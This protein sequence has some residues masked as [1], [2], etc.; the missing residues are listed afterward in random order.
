MVCESGGMALRTHFPSL[1]ALFTLAL[2]VPVGPAA[3]SQTASKRLAVLEF[4]GDGIKNEVKEAFAEAV[5]G[6]VGDGLAGRGVKV[7]DRENMMVLLKEMGKKECNEGECEVETARNIGADFVVSGSV[8]K[9]DDIFV[10]TLKLHETQEGSRLDTD[11]IEAKTQIEVLRSLRE[12]GRALVAKNINPRPAVPIPSRIPAVEPAPAPTPAPKS[13]A[14]CAA[15]QVA[16]PGGKFW[17]GSE[18]GDADEKPVRRVTLSPYC[19][20]K[21]EVTVSA[22]RACV[23]AGQ[24]RPPSTTVEWK[25]IKAEDKTKWSQFCTWGKSGL[26]QHPIN[27]VDWNQATQYCQWT[28]GR[29]PNE[30]EWEFAARGSDSRK[31]PWGNTAPDAT[32]LN[33]CGAECVS[34]A[35][36]RMGSDWWNPLYAG[37]DGWPAT[38][39][40]GRFPKG[41]SPFGV[42]D[43]AGNVWEW[44][45]DVYAQYGQLDDAYGRAEFGGSSRVSRGGG[46]YYP[47]LVR[48]AHRGMNDSGNRD[49]SL[50]FRCARGAKM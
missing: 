28:G 16:I 41:A 6:G 24:C 27:C 32:L 7:M 12:H 26:D 36:E 40:V 46:W 2:A 10:V 5:R 1:I 18:D 49:V 31:Y 21:T 42:L 19:I 43:M 14:V 8:V 3:S 17:M 13:V 39:P 25:E 11:Q 29:L 4:K 15:N 22:F 34:M 44:T 30:A 33:A 48:A 50:G 23:Q 35:K 45:S 20:D 37:K 47:S 9:V 38:A